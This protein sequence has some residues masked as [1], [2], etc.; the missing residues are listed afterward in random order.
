MLWYVRILHYTASDI[1][2][3][4]QYWDMK[5]VFMN[6]LTLMIPELL[7]GPEYQGCP[8]HSTFT[9]FY[10]FPLI[11]SARLT[12]NRSTI[13]VIFILYLYISRT[14]LG[15]GLN[16]QYWIPAVCS[17]SKHQLLVKSLSIH[18][19]Y[20]LGVLWSRVLVSSGSFPWSGQLLP[21]V[22][23]HLPIL[24]CMGN[25]PKII[26]LKNEPEPLTYFKLIW[27]CSTHL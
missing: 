1:K 26:I 24:M 5:S 22:P 20:L 27:T 3:V 16:W 25:W 17:T 2:M 13:L 23:C 14:Y 11:P 6:S 4:V 19:C 18:C 10:T 9:T 15:P 7:N 21:V 8:T 12:C